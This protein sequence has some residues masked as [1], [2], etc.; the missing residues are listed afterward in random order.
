MS[1]SNIYDKERKMN[2]IPKKMAILFLECMVCCND[3]EKINNQ[4]YGNSIEKEIFSQIKWEMKIN[5]E[6]NKNKYNKHL[7]GEDDEDNIIMN[8]NETIH[9]NK[10]YD[11]VYEEN[12]NDS[13]YQIKTIE[14]KIDIYPNNY[15]KIFEKK[16]KIKIK[17]LIII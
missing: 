4:I 17:I 10:T 5:A 11:S 9:S 8:H 1:Y 16:K 6:E 7:F 12:E 13:K 2:E 3:L 14:Q 15:Y